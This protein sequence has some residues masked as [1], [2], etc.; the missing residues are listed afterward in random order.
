MSPAIEFAGPL[1]DFTGMK[2]YFIILLLIG[3][4]CEAQT[5]EIIPRGGVQFFG[6][7]YIS[8]G[9]PK[10]ADF[11]H[12]IPVGAVSVGADIRYTRQ[13]HFSYLLSIESI[14]VGPSFSFHNVF[15]NQGIV[16]TISG[17]FAASSLGHALA[18]YGIQKE[19]NLGQHIHLSYSIQA[20]LAF[21]KGM[22]YY[23]SSSTESFGMQLGDSY[24]QYRIQYYRSGAGVFLSG[25]LGIGLCDK[26]KRDRIILQLLWHQ[27]LREMEKYRIQYQYG[28]YSNP[29]YQRNQLVILRSR[30]TVFGATV[31][32]PIRLLK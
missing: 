26:R 22:Q 1:N 17:H 15:L 28:Y 2:R 11:K 9:D 25:K 13:K 16:P 30:G 32:V 4:V 7:S 6:L 21:T 10:P 8:K 14:E 19:K 20:G 29:Q 18:S 3:K 5:L 27:G 23:D 12:N 31:G 24:Y